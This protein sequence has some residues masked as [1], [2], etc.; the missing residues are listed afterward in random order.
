MLSSNPASSPPP[1]ELRTPSRSV[2]ARALQPQG[3]IPDNGYVSP[4][5]QLERRTTAPGSPLQP[6]QQP[7]H[8]GLNAPRPSLS[9]LSEYH[10]GFADEDLG[11]PFNVA[12]HR[13]QHSFPNLLPLAFGSRTPSPTRKKHARSPSEQMPYTGDGRAAAGSP[14]GGGGGGLVSWLSGSAG[15]A[16]ALGLSHPDT[17]NTPRTSKDASTP[18]TTPT[19]ARKTP[20]GPGSTAAD[21]LTT[22]KSTTTT[23]ASR[24]MSALSSRFNPT[25]P[26]N[27]TTTTTQNPQQEDELC[28]LNLEAALFPQHSSSPTPSSPRPGDPFSPS[29]FKNLHMN[30]LGLLTKMQSAY[31]EQAAALRD[32]QAE[33]SAQRDELEEAV[34]RAAHLKMQLEG[35]ARRAAEQEGVVRGLMGEL[36]AE[37][38]R[39]RGKA[40]AAVSGAA[41]V[42]RTDPPPV[43]PASEGEEARSMVSED[44]GVDEDRR[45]R[46]RRRRTGGHPPRKSGEGEGAEGGEDTTTDDDDDENESAESE[47]V[48]S[49]CRSPALPLQSPMQAHP[50]ATTA[51]ASD[52]ASS[53]VIGVVEGPG[54]SHV[55]NPAGSG[56]AAAT[57]RQRAGQQQPMSAFQKILKGISGEDAGC[58]NCKGQD[59]SVA[60]DTVGLLRD[61]NR[62]L[63]TRVG[64]LEVAVEGAL[65]LVNG[66]G[67]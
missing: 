54:T 11:S 24:F 42:V 37:R 57:P 15:A 6:S 53:S 52:R 59:A 31:R 12:N 16:S 7:P 43:A 55:R 35:M 40:E 67:L 20:A 45:R 60:W 46:R 36:E 65:D 63:K 50:A 2:P 13:R 56:S 4:R 22:P 28:T 30:A 62:H 39:A 33:R 48:F 44:L 41:V 5:Q 3:A 18:N 21:Q 47:S 64:E 51:G 38:R 19:R 23:A 29:A 17:R 1:L 25:T 27:T 34:T 14:R 49:R 66:I 26:T 10:S 9:P 32:L 8:H 58:T 61:E